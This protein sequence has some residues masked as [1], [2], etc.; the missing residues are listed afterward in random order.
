MILRVNTGG[1][2][3]AKSGFTLIEL[4][5]VIVII[6]VL[7]A[8]V[9]PTLSRA[10]RS[11]SARSCL[12]NATQIAKAITM[13]GDD[14]N[15]RYPPAWRGA[16]TDLPPLLPA[17]SRLIPNA[18]LQF[19]CDEVLRYVGQDKRVFQCP[20]VKEPATSAQSGAATAGYTG[21]GINV[22]E[23]AVPLTAS[24]GLADLRRR[25]DV[26]SPSAT[27]MLADAADLANPSAPMTQWE[28]APKS[29]QVVWS[30][31]P[32]PGAVSARPFARHGGDM[33]VAFAA[34]NG[35]VVKITQAGIDKPRGDKD[36][37]WDRD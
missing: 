9:V 11:A 5:V 15:D 25:D 35:A 32:S 23:I 14:Y 36:A 28:S 37:M 4:L 21:I 19:W 30:A 3:R 2:D 13:F 12:N 34:G 17:A 33:A 31:P 26:R 7:A 18:S 29:S 16:A 6:G 24:R 8:L 27:I 22:S 1:T 20:A 10:L